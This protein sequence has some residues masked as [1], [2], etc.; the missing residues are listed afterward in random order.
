MREQTIHYCTQ[1]DYKSTRRWDRDRHMRSQHKIYNNNN[2]PVNETKIIQEAIKINGAPNHQPLHNIQSGSG[3]VVTSSAH[4]PIE[5]SRTRG[6]KTPLL[7][8]ET[9]VTKSTFCDQ[10][11]PY[12]VVYMA[13]PS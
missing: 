12:L 13:F 4:I 3:S 6:Y 11:I 1:C 7:V 2:I 10:M 5:K 8:K 9:V